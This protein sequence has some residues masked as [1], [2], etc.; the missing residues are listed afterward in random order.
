MSFADQLRVA[1]DLRPRWDHQGMWA[2][3]QEKNCPTRSSTQK[4][5]TAP[6]A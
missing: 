4:Q 5:A 1:S 6:M 3:R 2:I